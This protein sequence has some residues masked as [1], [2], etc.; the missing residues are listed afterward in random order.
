M[1]T[2]TL[3]GRLGATPELKTSNGKNYTTFSIADKQGKNVQWINVI[4][5]G[6]LAE[7]LCK[8]KQ[9]GE[10]IAITGRLQITQKDGKIY[11]NVSAYEIEYCGAKQD[12]EASAPAPRPE[13]GDPF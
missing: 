9:K 13:G 8:Y 3:I 7:N 12:A 10:T 5:S 6:T 2:I 11:T 4:A 1:N